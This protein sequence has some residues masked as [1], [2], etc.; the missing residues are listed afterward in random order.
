MD[1]DKCLVNIEETDEEIKTAFAKLHESFGK[2]IED[3]YK[4]KVVYTYTD[5][6]S[7]FSVLKIDT[8]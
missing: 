6:R 3:R 2:W 8:N 5:N 1:F 7:Q 4:L